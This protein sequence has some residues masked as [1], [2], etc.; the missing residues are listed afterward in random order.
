MG[1]VVHYVAQRGVQLAPIV[2]DQCTGLF[3]F[4]SGKKDGALFAEEFGFDDL[5]N[6]NALRTGEYFHAV[7]MG[8]C[9]RRALFG[10][11]NGKTASV[12][13]PRDDGRGDDDGREEESTKASD[14][15]GEG[16]QGNVGEAS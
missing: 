1:H 12:D 13:R 14:D 16:N 10:A 9:H 5:A 3:L 2:R 7:K 4:A 15:D 11:H 8:A 6:C